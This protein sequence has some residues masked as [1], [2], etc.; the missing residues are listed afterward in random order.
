[1]RAEPLLWDQLSE[2]GSRGSSSVNPGST[3]LS[4]LADDY[5]DGP[6]VTTLT[7][8]EVMSLAI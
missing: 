2:G 8:T 3:D 7:L 5:G 1:M 6:L 4:L